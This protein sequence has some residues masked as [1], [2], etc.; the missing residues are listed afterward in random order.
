MYRS[1]LVSLSAT[2]ST[3]PSPDVDSPDG[4][5][6]QTSGSGPSRS[7]STVVPA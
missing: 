3:A 5:A 2:H 1:A 6:I 7:A 4:C